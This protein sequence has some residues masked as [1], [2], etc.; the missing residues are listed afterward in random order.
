MPL[1]VDNEVFAMPSA[2]EART[3]DVGVGPDH[4]RDSE[5]LTLCKQGSN[6]P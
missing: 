4:Q 5:E 6:N 2:T 1:D 3:I